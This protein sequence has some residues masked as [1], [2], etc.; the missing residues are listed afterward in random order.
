MLGFVE[1]I[2]L[3]SQDEIALRQAVDF[4]RPGRDFD[5]SPGQKDVWVMPLLLSKFTYTVYKIKCSA[6][7]GKLEGLSDVVFFDDVPP[8]DLLLK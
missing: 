8:I 1:L 6:K 4:V 7:I 3:G 2:D 5:S